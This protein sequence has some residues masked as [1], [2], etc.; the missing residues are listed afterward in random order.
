M[1]PQPKKTPFKYAFFKSLSSLTH[2]KS[3]N[4]INNSSGF[5]FFPT[6]SIPVPVS[7][8]LPFCQYSLSKEKFPN[9]EEY[10]EKGWLTEEGLRLYD[11]L[12]YILKA[13]EGREGQTLKKFWKKR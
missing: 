8:Y 11:D 4:L 12:S 1:L 10:K 5:R 13:S 3:T 7:K 9:F 6:S 2:N